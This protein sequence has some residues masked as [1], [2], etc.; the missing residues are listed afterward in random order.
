MLLWHESKLRDLRPYPSDHPLA[1]RLQVDITG[2]RPLQHGADAV[3]DSAFEAVLRP[4]DVIYFPARWAHHTEACKSTEE[5]A[6]ES[7]WSL[8]FRTDGTYL[9]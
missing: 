7:S 3:G 1:R 6:Y 2:E 8:G 4:G 5:A 9:M